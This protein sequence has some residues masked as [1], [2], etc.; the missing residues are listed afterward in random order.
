MREHAGIHA[1]D[2]ES[3]RRSCAD[4]ASL[5]KNY[6]SSRPKVVSISIPDGATNV[7]PAT[8]E[9]IITF[10]RPMRRTAWALAGISSKVPPLTL[11]H[12]KDSA[13]SFNFPMG[14]SFASEAGALLKYVEVKFRTASA[15]P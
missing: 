12:G 7:D 1:G 2:Q 13:F 3:L 8:K 4:V 11:E 15:V 6:D 14:R 10:D 9:L 5:L